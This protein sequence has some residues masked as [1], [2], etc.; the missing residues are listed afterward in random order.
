MISQGKNVRLTISIP[1]VL[2]FI[3]NTA[4]VFLVGILCI[5]LLKEIVYFIQFFILRNEA[6]IHQLLERILVFFL[7]FEFIA[8]I[9]KYF[10]ENYHFPLRYFL[11]IGITAMTRLIIVH[12][13]NPLHTLLYACVILVLIISYYIINSTPLRRKKP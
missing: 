9:A 4:L 13:D 12:H 6:P 8:M 2:Q 10:Q 1:T 7:Y 3:L 11:Y 5:L